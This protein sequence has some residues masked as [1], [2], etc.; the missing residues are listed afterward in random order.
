MGPVLLGVSRACLEA[1]CSPILV[2]HARKHTGYEAIDL[3]DLA[4]AGVSEFARQW[5]LLSR[6]ERYQIGSGLQKLWLNVGGSIGHGGL[7]SVDICEGNIGDDFSGRKWD[8]TVQTH[9]EQ[10][11][12]AEQARIA[13][14]KQKATE[15]DSA[16][17][18]AL[19]VALD[20]LDPEKRG[21]SWNRVKDE[22]RLSEAR[23]ERATNRLKLA[24]IDE[25]EVTADIGSRAKRRVRG[26]RRKPGD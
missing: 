25:I 12:S 2:H 1:G 3:D 26:L 5:M 16:D 20:R 13:A 23:M 17:D 9:A 24:V 8:V 7:W 10:R 15:Q 6:R 22:S 21:C 19:M 18:T 14:K 4:F 11:Q